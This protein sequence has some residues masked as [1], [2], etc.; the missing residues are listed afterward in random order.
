M[1]VQESWMDTAQ[2]KAAGTPYE[3]RVAFF[4]QWYFEP[5]KQARQD[6]TAH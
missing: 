2:A 5:L 6:Y 1:A 4:R 3:A